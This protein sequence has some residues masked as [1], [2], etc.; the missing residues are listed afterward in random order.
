M[1]SSVAVVIPVYNVTEYLEETLR[2]VIRQKYPAKEII[3]VNDGADETPTKQIAQTCSKFPQVTL[4]T[5]PH[6]GPAAARDAGVA[7]STSDYIFFL[8]GDDTITPSALHYLVKALDKNP[9]AIA[10]YARF[11]LVNVKGKFTSKAKPSVERMLSGKDVLYKLLE[12]KLL[13]IVGTICIR[14]SVLEKISAHNHHLTYG[15]DW[16]LWCHLALAGNII[17]AGN[18]VIHHYR[19]HDRNSSTLHA[20]NPEPVFTSYDAVF[21][22]PTFMQVVGKEPL[23]KM[24]KKLLSYVHMRLASYYALKGETVKAQSHM[25]RIVLLPNTVM[26]R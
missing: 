12:L 5:K 17:P 16:V 24:E 6:A 19:K 4:L 25:Q 2:S 1:P 10:S 22:N 7:H 26:K 11:R 14:R 21:K 23:E 18:K 8:D 3:V 13:F 15:E 20:T 9:V